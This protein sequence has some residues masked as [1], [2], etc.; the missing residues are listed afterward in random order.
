MIPPLGI[1]RDVLD[2]IVEHARA[3]MPNEC[4][5]LLIGTADRITEAW[6]AR[7]TEGSPVRYVIHPEDHFNAIR[8]A[9]SLGQ[10]VL[11]AY[12]SH[13][14]SASVPS[15]TDV[16]EAI[17]AE[18]V[19]LIVSLACPEPDVRAFRIAN[20]NFAPAPLVPVA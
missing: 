2:A 3:E 14:H 9:R 11:G 5:G 16:S 10:T 7:N 8:R 13:T 4:C 17:S 18:F 19:Y 15:A 6:R 12:H 20:G 1:G